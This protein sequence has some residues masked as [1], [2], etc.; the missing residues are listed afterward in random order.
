MLGAPTYQ[1]RDLGQ[2]ASSLCPSLLARETRTQGPPWRAPVE[3]E[4]AALPGRG[5]GGV[6]APP[7]T[8][9]RP[10][11][12]RRPWARS[13]TPTPAALPRP[14]PQAPP[15]HGSPGPAQ[16]APSVGLGARGPSSPRGLLIGGPPSPPSSQQPPDRRPDANRATVLGQQRRGSRQSPRAR[17]PRAPP[18][19]SG[20][21]RAR[22]RG[23]AGAGPKG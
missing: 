11:D 12:A 3:P 6:R 18:P 10:G 16:I 22:R 13:P 8:S 2:V 5:V 19:A 1:L 21:L 15:L 7:P 14:A 23:G 4:G 9:T 20:K 17:S